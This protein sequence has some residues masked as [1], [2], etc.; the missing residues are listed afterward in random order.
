MHSLTLPYQNAHN[1]TNSTA[2]DGLESGF[3]VHGIIL[4]YTL[5][6]VLIYKVNLAGLNIT[7]L[8][9][10]FYTTSSTTPLTST[11]LTATL[12]LIFIT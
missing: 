3:C 5:L 9:L 8:E 2:K 6:T 10:V 1:S 12:G 7:R 11:L 4:Y